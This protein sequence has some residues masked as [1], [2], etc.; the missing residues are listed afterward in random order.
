MKGKEVVFDVD[1][2]PRPQTTLEA[3]SK[4]SSVFKK[5]GAVTAGN[6]SGINDGAGA[7]V[8]ASENAVS[9]KSL[10]PLARVV[11]YSVVGC[12]PE[13]MGIGPVPAI[14]KLLEKTGLTLDQV[15]LV[16]V[17]E[18][19]ASQWLAVQKELG[20]DIAKSNLN[21]GAIALGHPLGASGTRIL[22]NLTY[23]LKRQNAKYAIGSACIGGGQGIAVLLEN[24]K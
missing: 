11:A 23:E 10:K 16:E 3:L 8:L 18:A 6:A 24:V 2:H 4:L 9:Q 17:N 13:I 1:E 20:L 12:D 15:D 14:R 19:F 7:L 5:D 22:A 21:G